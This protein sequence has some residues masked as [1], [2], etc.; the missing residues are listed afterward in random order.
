MDDAEALLGDFLHQVFF[1]E[2]IT[3]LQLAYRFHSVE[4]YSFAGVLLVS[5]VLQYRKEGKF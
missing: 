4:D 5:K 2:I 3:V 1:K